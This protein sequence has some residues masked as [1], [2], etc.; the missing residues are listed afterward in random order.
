MS[1]TNLFTGVGALIL[2][3]FFAIKRNY[4]LTS[5]SLLVASSVLASTLAAAY[6]ILG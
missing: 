3:S 5:M 1:L 6:W 4:V 2:L